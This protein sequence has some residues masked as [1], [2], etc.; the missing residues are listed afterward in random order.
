MICAKETLVYVHTKPDSGNQVE[1]ERKD[2][3]SDL[4]TNHSFFLTRS[5][6]LR[7]KI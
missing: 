1:K 3:N 7:F 6:R 2:K 4:K 5:R